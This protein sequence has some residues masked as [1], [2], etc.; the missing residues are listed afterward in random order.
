MKIIVAASVIFFSCVYAYAEG[1]DTLIELARS[2]ANASKI[3]GEETD[4][5]ENIRKAL[6]SGSLEQGESKDTIKRR[7]GEP[8]V[9]FPKEKDKKETWVYKPGDAS[10]FDGPKIYLFFDDA[11]KLDGTK[12]I[13]K[14][15]E[16][17][18]LKEIE[19]SKNEM[20]VLRKPKRQRNRF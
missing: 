18:E 3:A 6:E 9:D 7:Y 10:F 14:K 1:L 12:T 20:P 19:K 15:E 16:K 13:E 17:K 11:G 8:V 4:H 5:F 2:K